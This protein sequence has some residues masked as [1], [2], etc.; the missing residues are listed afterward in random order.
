M[1]EICTVFNKV[2]GLAAV[3][4]KNLSEKSGS[5]VGSHT[6]CHIAFENFGKAIESC[7]LG[8]GIMRS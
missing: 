4:L 5:V 7:S 2:C 3:I 6:T 1:D 8:C